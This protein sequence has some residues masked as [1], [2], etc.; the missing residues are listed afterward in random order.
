MGAA[1]VNVCI[2]C[3]G[4]KDEET[5][6][7]RS[8]QDGPG[9]L[10]YETRQIFLLGDNTTDTSRTAVPLASNGME[11]CFFYNKSITSNP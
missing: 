9:S 2:V 8:D 3:S 11:A 6:R 1:S 10:R 4:W 5:R 7:D